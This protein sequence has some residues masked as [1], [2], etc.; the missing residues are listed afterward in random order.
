MEPAP[1][2]SLFT[3]PCRR[4]GIS[5]TLAL[6]IARTE[7]GI[8]PLCITI[9]GREH[10]PASFEQAARLAGEA[11]R[12]GRSVDLGLMQINSWWL[13]RLRLD[14]RDVLR[15]ATNVLLGVWIL[16]QEM[17][18]HGRVWKAVGAYH[19][20]SSRRRQ[21][22]VRR[23][24]RHYAE[25]A[26]LS[27]AARHALALRAGHAG[28]DPAGSGP[29]GS[30][31]TGAG[32]AGAELS[33]H[34]PAGNAEAA[35]TRGMPEGMKSASMS[36]GA[37]GRGVAALEEGMS[38]DAGK[39]Q[40]LAPQRLLLTVRPCD[41]GWPARPALMAAHKSVFGSG[42]APTDWTGLTDMTDGTLSWTIGGRR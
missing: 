6:A 12:Q 41:A 42:F 15:P 18:R 31:L 34:G 39:P 13:K 8:N 3:G 17:L 24:A 35:G 10:R 25:L 30:G 22:Y 32:L 26:E 4:F 23:V 27:P 29:A 1:V 37:A 9:E 14:P 19:S 16:H 11:M 5:E 20:P 38:R 7:S 33:G 40:V 21:A 28:S 36:P 2:R